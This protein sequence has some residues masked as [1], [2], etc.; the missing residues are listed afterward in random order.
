MKNLLLLYIILFTLPFPVIADGGR[1]IAVSGES[2][3]G[4]RADRATLQTVIM[5]VSKESAQSRKQVKDSLEAIRTSLARLGVKGDA[6][7]QSRI[8]QGKHQEWR[9]GQNVDL[10]YFSQ[11]MLT[12]EVNELDKLSTLYDQLS[13]YP[14]LQ[15]R[16]TSF[17]YSKRAEVEKQQ[18]RQAIL[19]ART[20]AEAMLSA[21]GQ[22][23][24][25][26]LHLSEVRREA[27]YARTSA[28]QASAAPGQPTV[29]FG[30]IEIYARVDVEFE[31]N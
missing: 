2:S 15:I 7:R 31:I 18:R 20:K 13:N 11:L 8:T 30:E 6:L 25:Q 12:I 28:A 14:E 17:D 4:V 22:E 19:D 23:L 1:V 29:D 5:H 16:H 10:G 21:L 24:G 26:V 27:P 9:K 3:A